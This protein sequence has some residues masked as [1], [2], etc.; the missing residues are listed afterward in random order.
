MKDKKE[1]INANNNEIWH[2][3]NLIL[4]DIQDINNEHLL[5]QLKLLYENENKINNIYIEKF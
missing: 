5:K 2:I 1:I 4:F 3:E